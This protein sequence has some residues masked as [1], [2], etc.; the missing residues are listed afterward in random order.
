MKNLLCLF[1]ILMSL[2]LLGACGKREAA[3]TGGTESGRAGAPAEAVATPE[4]EDLRPTPELRATE[5]GEADSQAIPDSL[6]EKYEEELYEAEP[7][8]F[9]W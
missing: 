3:D 8:S 7:P 9:E 2:L 4:P 1:T 6:G 5:T